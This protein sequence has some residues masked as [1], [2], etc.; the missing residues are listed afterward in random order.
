MT[1]FIQSLVK[2]SPVDPVAGNPNSLQSRMFFSDY[3]LGSEGPF[4]SSEGS[5]SPST[6]LVGLGLEY[7]YAKGGSFNVNALDLPIDYRLNFKNPKWSMLFNFPITAT[8]TEGQWS[9]LA[10]LAL[11]A[12]YR[13]FDWWSITPLV[14]FGG[15]GSIDVGALALMYSASVTNHW[16]TEWEGFIFGFSNLFGFTKTVDGIEI[17]GIDISYELTNPL[18]TNG[19]YVAGAILPNL[20]WKFFGHNTQ[21]WGDDLY[22]DSQSEVGLALE[23]LGSL[24][25]SSFARLS[26]SAS[27]VFGNNDYDGLAIRL[28]GRF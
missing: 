16:H 15:A 24:G 9:V 5:L 23:M 4:T 28:R 10:S 25:E 13:P 18:T 7:G 17:S 6:D 1:D 2:N 11:G 21:I 22:M 19:G 14:R 12:Q 27:Y 3:R 20:G 8:F 26:L